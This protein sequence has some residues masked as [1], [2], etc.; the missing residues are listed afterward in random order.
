MIQI[1]NKSVLSEI[2][3]VVDPSRCALM[4]IDIQNDNVGRKGRLAECGV[5]ISGFRE[6]IPSL[7]LLIATARDA[8]VPVIFTRN[9]LTA[10]HRGES[11]A[12][13]RHL[14]KSRHL[15]NLDEYVLE[16]SWGNSVLD[17]L[18]PH[19]DDVQIVKYRS[20]AF[21]GTNLDLV[22]RGMG[23]TS[24]IVCGIVTEGCVESTVRD[25]IGYGYYA[26]VVQDAVGSSRSELHDAAMTVM[27]A[28]YDVVASDIIVECWSS[29]ET[30]A[31]NAQFTGRRTSEKGADAADI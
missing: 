8:S 9:T 21:H 31:N 28:R 29:S 22:L 25:L 6:L 12:Q 3:E 10:N 4:I 24:V 2:T 16:G 7:K 11:A 14:S 20:S 13:L 26:V 5:D 18:D 19:P 27:A 30:T 15:T 1:G 17:E 23:I